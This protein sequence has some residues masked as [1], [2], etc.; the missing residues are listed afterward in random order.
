[1]DSFSFSLPINVLLPLSQLT[2]KPSKGVS[3]LLMRCNLVVSLL[4]FLGIVFNL[5]LH[6]DILPV[7]CWSHRLSFCRHI[8]DALCVINGITGA[9]RVLC[10]VRPGK[11][12]VSERER[13]IL[14]RG[15]YCIFVCLCEMCLLRFSMMG[16]CELVFGEARS[17]LAI[18]VTSDSMIQCWSYRVDN[19][20]IG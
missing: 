18:G 7:N 14:S 3:I 15:I 6:W 2:R 12:E 4:L 20:F 13:E 11:T 19:R 16:S 8:F 1:M 9:V 10:V 5:L 17:L